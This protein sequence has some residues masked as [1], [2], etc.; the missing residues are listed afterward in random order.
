[1]KIFELSCR[2]RRE[3]ERISQHNLNIKIERDK[4]KN[5]KRELLNDLFIVSKSAWLFT[6]FV[7]VEFRVELRVLFVDWARNLFSA[8]RLTHDCDLC[9]RHS[10][11]IYLYINIYNVSFIYFLLRLLSTNGLRWI[12]MVRLKMP[13]SRRRLAEL[14]ANR[15]VRLLRSDI[16]LPTRHHKLYSTLIKLNS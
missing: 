9:F 8:R 11:R 5:R 3:I 6:W 4:N 16:R 2:Y 1:M 12:R 10:H 14:F 15:I 13:T 7:W